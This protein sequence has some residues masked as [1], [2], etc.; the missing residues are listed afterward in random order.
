MTRAGAARVL[1]VM[2]VVTLAGYV[3]IGLFAQRL[4]R[5]GVSS[6]HLFGGGFTLNA[7]GAP[8]HHRARARH[9]A[10]WWA[11]YG[12]GAAVNVLSFTVLNEGFARNLTAR[13]NTALNLVM[14]GGSFVVQWGIGVVAETAARSAGVDGGSGAAH[15]VRAR[16]GGGCARARVVRVGM[17]A[18]RDRA[19]RRPRRHDARRQRGGSI[20]SP[21]RAGGGR[22]RPP[23]RTRR[24]TRCATRSRREPDRADAWHDLGV[25]RDAARPRDRGARGV[26]RGRAAATRVG[27]AVLRGRPRRLRARRF[28]RARRRRS[29]RRSRAR[30]TIWPR[31]STS[32]RR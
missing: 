30:R 12:L 15:R 16:A 28:R 4:A 21:A 31:A 13:A 6:R 10:L 3:G 9:A 18:A 5:H 11:L 26:R 17:A 20:R 1:L 8:L 19:S 14:F 29:R 32:R 22:V 27:R 24:S 23:R 2:G 7:V 25:L